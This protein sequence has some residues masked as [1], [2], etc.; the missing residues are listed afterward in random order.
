MIIVVVGNKIL[1]VFWIIIF[2]VMIEFFVF[3]DFNLKLD[4]LELFKFG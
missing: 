4:L 1:R 2:I 3:L